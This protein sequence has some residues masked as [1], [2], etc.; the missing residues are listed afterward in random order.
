MEVILRI[1]FF[2][3]SDTNNWFAKKELIW[4]SYITT[5]ALLTTKKVKLINKR[6]FAATD[7]DKNSET[8]VI[9]VIVLETMSIHSINEAQIALL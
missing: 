7:I 6:E 8:F 2:I 5:K 1:L 4:R 3:F 9:H